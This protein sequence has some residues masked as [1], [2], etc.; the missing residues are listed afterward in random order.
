MT[1]RS[2]KKYFIEISSMVGEMRPLSEQVNGRCFLQ[3]LNFPSTHYYGWKIFP[4]VSKRGYFISGTVS[5]LLESCLLMFCFD[6]LSEGFS[7]PPPPSYSHFIFLNSII[8]G[9]TSSFR[10]V[11]L[12]EQKS[13]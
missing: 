2:L 8:D 11:A 3:F 10:G 4:S 12:S 5:D 9:I 6:C 13:F 7:L 1:D